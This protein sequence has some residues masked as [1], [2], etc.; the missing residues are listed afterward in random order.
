MGLL[1]L[2][3]VGVILTEAADF[4]LFFSLSFLF[5]RDV[6]NLLKRR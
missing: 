6:L 1:A 3:S 4:F 5:D 2:C